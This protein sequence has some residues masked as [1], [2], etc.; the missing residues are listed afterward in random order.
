MYGNYAQGVNIVHCVSVSR[1]MCIWNDCYEKFKIKYPGS[2]DAEIGL[3]LSGSS[4]PSHHYPELS[5][6]VRLPVFGH[7]NC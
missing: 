1:F 4:D 7:T 3:A 6:S 2:Q 5:G